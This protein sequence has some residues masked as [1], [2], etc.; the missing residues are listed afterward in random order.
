MSK[1]LYFLKIGGSIITD[2]SRPRVAR[3]A[4]MRR[5]LREIKEAKRRGNFQLVIGHGGGSFPHTTAKKYKVNEGL[6]HSYSEKGASLTLLAARELNDIFINEG[7]KVGLV[8]FSFTP[9][10]F[11]VWDGKEAKSGTVRNIQ[12]ALRRGMLP[13]VYG[14]VVINLERGVSIAST[15]SVFQFLAKKLKPKKIIVATDIDGVFDKDPRK[16][17]DANLINLINRKNIAKV[18]GM[19]SGS[20]KIDVTGGMKTKLSILYGMIRLTHA[21]GIITNG[22]RKNSIRNALLG[23]N[24]GRATIV[25]Y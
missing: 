18:M 19:T 6:V 17:K 4:E 20:N 14:D 21:K 22:T 12:E 3:R 15:E 23:K 25:N 16:Y 13:V 10:S 11:G 5:I 7:L 8:M 9:S 24:Y 2:K 1:K